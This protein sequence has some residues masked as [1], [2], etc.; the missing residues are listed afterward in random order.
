[1]SVDSIMSG[2]TG[3]I[4]NYET[5]DIM[6][7]SEIL[8]DI[9]SLGESADLNAPAREL[10]AFLV[11]IVESEIQGRLSPDFSGRLSDGLDL[12]QELQK[13]GDEKRLGRIGDKAAAFMGKASSPSQANAAP[14]VHVGGDVLAVFL[15]DCD[16]RMA[17]AEEIILELERDLENAELINELFRIFHTIKG[18]CGFLRI[19]NLGELSHNLENVL[20]LMR[21][22]KLKAAP[23]V[24]DGFLEGVDVTKKILKAL[25]N[26]DIDMPSKVVID[27]FIARVAKFAAARPPS[28]GEVLVQSGQVDPQ[29][30]EML[31]RE[32]KASGFQKKLGQLAVEAKVITQSQLS[33]SLETQKKLQGSPVKQERIE[34][35]VKVKAAKVN[36]LTDMIGELL[37]AIGQVQDKSSAFNQVRKISKALQRAA[38]E[39]RTES[40]KALFGNARRVVRDLT[41]KLG[42]DVE[43]E[44]FG[45]ELEIDRN[46][47]EKL[48]EPIMHIVRNSLDHGIEGEEERARKGKSVKGKLTI[49]AERRGNNIVISVAD[50]GQGLNRE[51]ILSKAIQKGLVSAKDAQAMPDNAIFNLIFIQGFSTKENVDYVSGRGVGM[52]IVKTAVIKAKGRVELQTEKDSYTRILLIFPLSTAIIEGMLVRLDRTTFIV[53]IASIIESISVKAGG[54]SALAPG[55]EV[56][57]VR[58]EPIPLVRLAKTLRLDAPDSEARTAVIVENAE[59]RKF[60]LAVDEILAKREVVIKPLGAMFKDLKGVSSGTVLAGGRIGLVLDVDQ[61]VELAE[62]SMPPP[63]AAAKAQS[64]K[65]D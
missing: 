55:V 40:V 15:S 16:G 27:D 61:I 4:L 8:D 43:L 41:A 11:S 7:A 13:G 44:T 46:L 36:Y 24:I 34:Q 28:L 29:D 50:D 35:I 23:R 65:E 18:E 64:K 63:G 42:K 54:I 12:L 58:Q 32:Q 60:A 22:G 47:I 25:G 5:G 45:E 52:D 49:G 30:L 6:L 37:I 26:A 21:T 14:A 3:K 38:M 39:L 31:L 62:G 53:P 57:T 20:D 2:L 1:M 9:K 33:E 51:K 19:D 17:R 10:H 48:E 56:I 59:K